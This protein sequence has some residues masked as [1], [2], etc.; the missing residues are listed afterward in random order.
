MTP[1][2]RSITADEA[3]TYRTAIR[4]GFGSNDTVDDDEWSRA[5]IRP[6]ERA[7]AAF[8]QDRIVATFQSF[9]TEVTL[10]GGVAV[11]GGGVTAVTC[12]AT[13]RRQGILT[14]MMNRDLAMSR[15]HGEV[16]D[17]L[18]AAEYPIYGRFGYGPAVL[19]SNWELDAT[20]E[21]STPGSGTV[22]YIDNEAFRKEAPAIFERVR[23]A[24]PGMI[25]RDDLDWDVRADLRR[26]PEDKPWTGFRLLVRD[27]AGV[28]QGWANYEHKEHWSDMRPSATAEVYDLCAVTPAAEARLWR[29]LAE[30]DHVA[31]VKSG[32]RPLDEI[33]PWLLV[34]GR[35]AKQ[36]SRFDFIWV[37]PLDVPA[38]LTTRSY[39]ATGGAV[40]EIIDDQG[41][42]GGR[43][44]LDASP[45]GAT[46][47]VT[48][49]SADVTMSVRTLGTA[50]LGGVRLSSLQAPRWTDQHAP[51]CVV[52]ADA[53]LSGPVTPWCNTWF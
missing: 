27:D 28:A 19:A 43:F 1:E 16:V 29:F 15:E 42:A 33:L 13:H 26:R 38:L 3:S 5:A 44:A 2:I 4:A 31:T 25:G 6:V 14:R 37:R 9:P 12:R 24:R 10:P 22:E 23:L 8:D 51:R 50:S 46:C 34:N 39:T 30:L 36:T 18:I 40:L 53:L 32:D 47:V 52:I 21:F 7:L 17:V 11:P 35:A 45:D 20:A 41:L 48:D 49:R